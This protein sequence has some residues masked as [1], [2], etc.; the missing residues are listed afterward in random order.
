MP[1]S[2]RCR[3]LLLVLLLS[4]MPLPGRA[5]ADPAALR[6]AVDDAR[7]QGQLRAVLVRVSVDGEDLLRMVS[8]ESLPGQPATTAMR[9]RSGAVAMAYLATLLLRLAEQGV[10][11]LDAPVRRWLPEVPH[12]ER[13]SLRQLAQMTAGYRDDVRNPAFIAAFERNPFRRWR[14]EQLLAFAEPASLL[15][16]PGTNWNYSH[17]ST[18]LLGMALERAGGAPLERLLQQQVLSPLGLK[19]TGDTGTAAIPPP[20]LHAYSEERRSA[21]A[22]P[23]ERG[24]LEESTFWDPSW[25]LPAGAVQTTTLDDLHATA[26]G[27]GG[28][29]LLTPASYRAMVNTDLRGRTTALPGCGTCFPQSEGYTFGMGIVTTG[30]WLTQN[31]LFGGYAAAFGYH[32]QR[33]IAIAVAVTFREEAFQP[34]GTYVNE[35]DRLFRRLGALLPP[36]D[37]PPPPRQ[38]RP[39]RGAGAGAAD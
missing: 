33:R 31:P 23:P 32:P 3:A 2:R 20:V 19:H 14:S 38:P 35:A 21:L 8:G 16:P 28:G 34:D 11:D 29:A 26:V 22:L 15:Y 37:P 30:R 10:V 27:I 39:A 4:L 1:Q 17:T 25:T 6:S 12:T 18:L 7:R 13:V 5:A 36:E 9:F 24:F